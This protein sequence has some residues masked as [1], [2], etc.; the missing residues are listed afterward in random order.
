MSLTRRLGNS[1]SGFNEGVLDD[2][3]MALLSSLRRRTQS[4]EVTDVT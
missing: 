3:A 1:E 2:E 4:D